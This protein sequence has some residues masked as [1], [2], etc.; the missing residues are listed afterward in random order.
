MSF[1]LDPRARFDDLHHLSE[2]LMGADVVLALAL[3]PLLV[4]RRTRA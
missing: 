3:L 1:R 4:S 2:R